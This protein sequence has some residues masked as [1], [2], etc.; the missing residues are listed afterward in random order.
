MG[1]DA[2]IL[3]DGLADGVGVALDDP[4]L[5]V[6]EG[7]TRPATRMSGGSRTCVVRS[8]PTARPRSRRTILR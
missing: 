3:D 5:R 2:L 6:V 7:P 1:S 8:I 4:S